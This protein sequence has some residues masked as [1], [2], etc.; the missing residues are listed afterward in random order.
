[1]HALPA[2]WARH[3]LHGAGAI[4]APAADLDPRHAAVTSGKQRGVPPEQTIFG[5]RFRVFLRGVENHVDDPVDMT[6]RRRKPTNVQPETARQRR[7]DL[8]AI[9][10]LAFDLTGL[11][12]LFGERL[13]RGLV[14]QPQPQRLHAANQP[15]LLVAHRRERRDEVFL[16]P[17]KPGPVLVLVDIPRHSPHLLR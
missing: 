11:D 10:N 1:M 3:H 13:Q 14:A 17:A 12:D 16:A 4:V 5:Q 2:Q 9:E 7:T 8:I 15:A 6:V